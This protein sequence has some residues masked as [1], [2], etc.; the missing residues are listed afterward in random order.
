MIHVVEGIQDDDVDL[1]Q[2]STR[3]VDTSRFP[4]R[5]VLIGMIPI[6]QRLMVILQLCL[7]LDLLYN[8]SLFLHMMRTL[9][10]QHG[11]KL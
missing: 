3:L 11:L 8:N 9:V 6:S 1:L 4:R 7:M 2:N 5:G 10:H